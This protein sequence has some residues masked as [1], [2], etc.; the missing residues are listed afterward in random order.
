MTLPAAAQQ[1]SAKNSSSNASPTRGIYWKFLTHIIPAMTLCAIFLATI[2]AYVVI[3]SAEEQVLKKLNTINEVHSQSV[4]YPLWTLDYDSLD[5]ELKTIAIYPEVLCVEVE[6]LSEGIRFSWP[7]SCG[8]QLNGAKSFT[9]PLSYENKLIGQLYLGYT[10]KPMLQVL[11]REIAIGFVFFLILTFVAGLVAFASLRHIVGRPLELLMASINKAKEADTRESVLWWSNDELGEVIDSYNGLITQV[12]EK[13]DELVS[14]RVDAEKATQS[15]GQFL[16][17]MSHELRTPL[18][19]VI[20]ITEMLRE[21]AEEEERD[22]EAYDRVAGS[23][24]H[25][26]H[27]IDDILLFAKYEAREMDIKMAEL[28][29]EDLISD[30]QPIVEPLANRANNTLKLVNDSQHNIMYSDEL[31]LRQIVLNLLS[32]AAKFTTNGHIQLTICD[33]QVHDNPGLKFSVTDNGIGIK[34]EDQ[35]SIF[36]EFAQVDESTT[37]QY[38]GTGLGLA[39]SQQLCESL[40]GKIYVISE[41]GKG[42]EFYFALPVYPD[43]AQRGA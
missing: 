37:R 20:G 9:K 22:T 12:S 5:R 39:I 34:E 30:V 24:R 8:Q 14:A 38:G 29:I 17:N 35:R 41:L 2:Y 6:D 28:S 10:E 32:N 26:L 3:A 27:L 16:A 7:E 11:Y 40:G 31:R 18:N 21:E 36:T 4:S 33:T 23:G 1:A 42:S 43:V 19:S 13:T 25:L 15:K